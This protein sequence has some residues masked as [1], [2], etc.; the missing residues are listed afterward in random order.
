MDSTIPRSRRLAALGLLLAAGLAA[1]LALPAPREAESAT[2]DNVIFILTD[3]QSAS[4]LASMPN[5]Q[6]LIGGQG[7]TFRRTYVPYPLCCPSR[8]G[9]LTGQY[10]HN[11]GVRG[12][13]LP[14]GG[15]D[16]FIQREADA[17]PVWTSDAGYYNVHIGKYMNGYAAAFKEPP[18]PVPA[19]WDEWYGKLSD[20]ALYFNYQLIEK[21]GPGEAPELAFYGDQEWEYQTD[22]FSGKTVDFVDSAGPGET[23]F[24]LNLWFNAPHGPFDPAPRHLYTQSGPLPKVQAFNEKDVSDKPKWLRKQTRK[25]I[26]KSLRRTIELER[27]RRLEM[28]RSV[29]EG[30]G[31]IVAELAQEGMLDDTYIVFASDNGFFRGEHR[32]AGG[33]YLA[34]EPSARVPMMIRGPGIPPGAV[35]DELVSALDITQTVVE[36]A[37]GTPDPALDGRSLLRY[38]ENPALRSTRPLLLEADTG[39]GKGVPGVDALGASASAAAAKLARARLLGRR[40]VKDLDQERMA[41][42]SAANG[43]FAPAYRAV[44]TDRYL[45]VLYSNRQS[46]LYDMRHDPGQLRNRAS[47]PRYKPVRKWLYGHLV[48]LTGCAGESCRTEI[49]PDPAPLK[50]APRPPAPAPPRK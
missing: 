42:E 6:A 38:A 29:D 26:G 49:G 44:R 36:I 43:N 48:G 8:A 21:T 46:E 37:T 22:V 45:Y 47:D 3:D 24:M 41:T 33:K 34:Y 11:H 7:A 9:L 20:G 35:S 17:L 13:T 23:P 32:I 2:G 25:R 39:P 31:A 12:N 10:M 14:Y 18:F 30:V 28:L 5:T 16:R 15:W 19:G 27:R 50:R 40:G 1:A 4:E